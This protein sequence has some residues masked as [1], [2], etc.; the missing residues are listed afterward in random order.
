MAHTTL[1][2]RW[3]DSCDDPTDEQMRAALAELDTPDSEHPDCWLSDESEWSIAAFE[4]GLVVLE[5]FASDDETWHL[6]G[7]DRDQVLELWRLL[8]AG[9]LTEIR[10]RNWLRGYGRE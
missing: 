3:G 6:K 4:S 8:R 5:R 9:N 10:K 7:Q 2:F 1:T